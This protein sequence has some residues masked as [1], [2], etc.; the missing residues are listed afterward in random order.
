MAAPYSP[1]EL[2]WSP[3]DLASSSPCAFG[4]PNVASLS[5]AGL[6]VMHRQKSA[7]TCAQVD[8]PLLEAELTK[9]ILKVILLSFVER[10][11]CSVQQTLLQTP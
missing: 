2:C 10:F 8:K 1:L 11:F 7:L 6:A 3:K 5:P 9:Q 4:F